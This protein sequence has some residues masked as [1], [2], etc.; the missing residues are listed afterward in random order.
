MSKIQAL[1]F[2]I[3]QTLSKNKSK[4]KSD[5]HAEIA[6]SL[7]VTKTDE[8]LNITWIANKKNKDITINNNKFNFYVKSEFDESSNATQIDSNETNAEILTL[9]IIKLSL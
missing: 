6:K 5:L 7:N 8:S 2:L 3:L 4:I 1:K 9:Q